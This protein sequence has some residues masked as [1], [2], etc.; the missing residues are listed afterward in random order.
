V[1]AI[2]LVVVIVLIIIGYRLDWTG[3]NGYNQVT[4]TRTISG[5]NSGTATRTEM[6][7]PGKGLWDWLQ[8]LGL[9]AIPVVVGIGA[10]WFT[11]RQ[12]HDREIA[13]LQRNADRE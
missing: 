4:I 13:A 2:V 12:N 6:Y 5:T 11:A 7:Q 1:V 8:L 10:A 3:F 9:I